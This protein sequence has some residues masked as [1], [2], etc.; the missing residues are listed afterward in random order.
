LLVEA[1]FFNKTNTSKGHQKTSSKTGNNTTWYDITFLLLLMGK[2]LQIRLDVMWHARTVWLST[3][4][5][6][7]G[8]PTHNISSFLWYWTCYFMEGLESVGAACFLFSLLYYAALCGMIKKHSE[9]VLDK[10]LCM[11]FKRRFQGFSIS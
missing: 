9:N 5:S 10:L 2:L 11:H 8:I 1:L 7:T 3:V 4:C 6:V